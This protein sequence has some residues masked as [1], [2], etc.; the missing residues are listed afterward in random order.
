MLKSFQQ[1][2]LR[3]ILLVVV[4]TGTGILWLS[5]SSPQGA[6]S[7]KPHQNAGSVNRAR[8]QWET[9]LATQ[10]AGDAACVSCHPN[11]SAAHQR[12]GHSHTA[13]RMDESELAR[14]LMGTTYQDASDGR[15]V[16][17][18]L[19]DKGFVAK[20]SGQEETVIN[21]VDWLLGSAT[22]AQTAV[23]I[24]E[25][26]NAG[27]EHCWTWFTNHNKLGR[28]PGQSDYKPHGASIDSCGGRDMSAQEV[29]EC[30]GCHMTFGPA[31]GQTL[32][33][34]NWQPNISCERCHGPRRFHS[35]A[36]L[37]GQAEQYKPMVNLK[38]PQVEMKLC[39]QCHRDQVDASTPEKDQ[40]RFQPFRLKK[41]RCYQAGPSSL[42]C[43][44]CHDPHDQTSHNIER[45][46]KT[47]L[48]CHSQPHQSQCDRDQQLDLATDNCIS[49]HMPKREW[50]NGIE[51]VD[52][53]I[54]VVQQK[55]GEK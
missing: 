22:H 55:E 28:T 25:D 14:R 19:E 42:T 16:D 8:E 9:L 30:F 2:I 49:C 18:A 37:V 21:R 20:V 35:E 10:F 4:L 39:A 23:S 40:I 54:R 46:Q 50:N 31:P 7:E 34:V 5:R 11:E 41:A 24:L 44:T 51:F 13:F 15:K 3:L 29:T 12:S 32:S 1:R 33:E 17:F 26:E 43:T 52:H 48:N 53:W 45:Y 47:C 36:A 38:D 6:D 27:L